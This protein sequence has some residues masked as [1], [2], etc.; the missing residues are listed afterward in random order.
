M[1]D[2]IVKAITTYATNDATK[3]TLDENVIQ[4][5]ARYVDEKVSSVVRLFHVIGILV[6][7]QTIITLV[8]LVSEFRR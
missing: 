8:L 1:I 2:D 3:K 6:L 7:I 5:C 4:P